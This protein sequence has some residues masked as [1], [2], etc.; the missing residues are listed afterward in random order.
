M[1]SDHIQIEIIYILS[2]AFVKGISPDYFD[3]LNVSE[4]SKGVVHELIS[5]YF[6]L[7]D[8]HLE[9]RELGDLDASNNALGKILDSISLRLISKCYMR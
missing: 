6:E 8:D 7:I 5:D 1:S 4:E 2:R 9:A 3:G